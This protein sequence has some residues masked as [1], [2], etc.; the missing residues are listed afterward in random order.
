MQSWPLKTCNQDT[1]KIIILVLAWS[2]KL[3]QQIHVEEDAKSLKLKMILVLKKK[4]IFMDKQI[5]SFL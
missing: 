1:L 5:I 2:F 3:G 4:I